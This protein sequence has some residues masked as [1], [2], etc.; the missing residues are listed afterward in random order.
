VP[1]DDPPRALLA[2]LGGL[3]EGRYRLVNDE[4]GLAVELTWPVELFPHVWLWQELHASPGFPWFR[5]AYAMAVEP[6][7]T[8]PEGGAPAMPFAGRESR[9]SVVTA[10]VFA[11]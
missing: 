3:D 9:E 1:G 2:Y 6:H 8:V 5:R 4:L 10:R 7:T 11:P